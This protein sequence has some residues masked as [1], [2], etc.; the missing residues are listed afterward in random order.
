MTFV[1]IST[2]TLY[3]ALE[4]LKEL[5]PDP[6]DSNHDGHDA[7]DVRS[8]RH[9]AGA[10]ETVLKGPEQ[11]LVPVPEGVSQSDAEFWLSKRAEII[12]ACKTQGF[13]IVT[14]AN[15][16]QLMRLGQIEAQAE[17]RQPVHQL[18]Q[19][20]VDDEY[21]VRADGERVRKDRW[22][23]GIRRIVA[24]LWGNRKEFEI[25]EVVE[26]VRV[27]VPRPVAEGND[28]ALVRAV[29]GR[30][31]S[32]PIVE[33]IRAEESDEE[34][35]RQVEGT[36]C[37]A[38][39]VSNKAQPVRELVR[40][41][42]VELFHVNQQ[43]TSIRDE[44]GQPYCATGSTVRNILAEAKSFLEAE[45]M[46]PQME[47]LERGVTAWYVERVAPGMRDHGMKLGP[48]FK[49]SEAEQW[50]D[51]R[52]VLREL[53]A[54]Q[55]LAMQHN[56]N[57]P[58]ATVEQVLS[59]LKDCRATGLLDD[60]A[61]KHATE[62]INVLRGHLAQQRTESDPQMRHADPAPLT[63]RAIE[64]E[65]GHRVSDDG[66][67]GLNRMVS[68]AK[69][70][71]MVDAMEWAK[72][73]NHVA[74]TYKPLQE[75][76]AAGRAVLQAPQRG[77]VAFVPVHPL[78]GPLW[79]MTTDQPNPERLPSYPLMML[80]APSSQGSSEEHGQREPDVDHS[81]PETADR[82]LDRPTQ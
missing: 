24:L 47:P 33:R 75:A 58:R 20:P 65:T 70:Q 22:Q 38:P 81:D 49:K 18:E 41:L 76:I 82:R 9:T 2:T 37:A 57:L 30:R 44:D 29:L 32:H 3:L 39:Q 26:A 60:A 7:R 21:E 14:T 80:Y 5:L 43:L 28:E 59:A 35:Q 53:V 74:Q 77:M 46:P 8:W 68:A 63:Q 13:N 17:P 69:M 15:G 25:D 55:G 54:T 45:T 36:F 4:A 31:E 27:L 42:Y 19:E 52:H 64:I 40:R 6:K 67:A 50:V 10:L 72:D 56:M 16:V 66:V 51:D 1:S 79:A 78:Q 48:W 11:R 73:L 61:W 34:F 12:D 23:V 71:Q 62:A